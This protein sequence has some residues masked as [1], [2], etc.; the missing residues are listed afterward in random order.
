[1]TKKTDKTNIL[2]VDDEESICDL[3][4]TFLETSYSFQSVAVANNVSTAIG[5]MVNVK[6]DL[7]II[8]QVMPGKLGLEFIDHLKKNK[9]INDYKIILIS[10]YLHERD[11]VNAIQLGVKNIVVKPFTKTQ[12]IRQVEHLLQINQTK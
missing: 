9:K 4:K 12:L 8:D 1:M 6:Y 3:I 7:I 5:K 10:G 11:V 2:I